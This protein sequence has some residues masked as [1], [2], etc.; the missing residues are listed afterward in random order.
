MSSSLI[1]LAVDR[2]HH[3]PVPPEVI[4]LVIFVFFCIVMMALLMFGKGRPHA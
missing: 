3:L 4:G 1:T 2:P